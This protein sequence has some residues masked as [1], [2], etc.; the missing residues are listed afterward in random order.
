M[1]NSADPAQVSP[2]QAPAPGG[3]GGRG[4]PPAAPS[5]VASPAASL[6]VRPADDGLPRTGTR[7]S[8]GDRPAHLVPPRS[9][10]VEGTESNL[11]G[12]ARRSQAGPTGASPRS[13]TG[14]SRHD[15][16][17]CQILCGRS[18]A[19]V[20]R[21]WSK[22]PAIHQEGSSA[23][24]CEHDSSAR[25][26]HVA[27]N[28]RRPLRSSSTNAMKS[29]PWRSSTSLGDG[30]KGKS[31]ETETRQEKPSPTTPSQTK[32]TRPPAAARYKRSQC[33][34]RVLR[35]VGT[36]AFEEQRARRGG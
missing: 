24:R 9:S 21:I 34:P 17:D 3:H 33:G 16:R 13:L 25:L 6:Y 7:K 28:V 23:S 18:H 36:A 19:V 11:R 8:I 15:R 30:T 1:L 31:G 2:T 32:T 35:S 26:R 5:S 22:I 29:V 10:G 20:V 12:R 27:R 14:D 4:P